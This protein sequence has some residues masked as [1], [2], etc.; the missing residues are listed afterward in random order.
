MSSEHPSR[1]W[2]LPVVVTVT[3]WAF[4]AYAPPVPILGQLIWATVVLLWLYYILT[5]RRVTTQLNSWRMKVPMFVVEILVFLIG[6][7][8]CV[9]AFILA[10]PVDKSDSTQLEAD[11][12]RADVHIVQANLVIEHDEDGQLTATGIRLVIRNLGKRAALNVLVRLWLGYDNK[13]EM[14]GPVAVWDSINVLDPGPYN[15]GH[16]DF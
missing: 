3:G 16:D 2:L 15:A 6:G 1:R 7:A 13:P 12:E 9:G 11:R 14:T 10:R 5:T 8:F 4:D